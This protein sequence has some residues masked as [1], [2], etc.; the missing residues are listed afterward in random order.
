M[1]SVQSGGLE[2]PTQRKELEGG[3]RL[4]ALAWRGAVGRRHLLGIR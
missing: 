3:I 4:G 1:L 2:P